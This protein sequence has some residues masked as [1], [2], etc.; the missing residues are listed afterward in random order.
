MF[1]SLNGV[2]VLLVIETNSTRKIMSTALTLRNARAVYSA[3]DGET[4]LVYFRQHAPDIIVTELD[5]SPMSGL[6]MAQRIRGKH[7]TPGVRDVPIILMAGNK[8][9]LSIPHVRDAGF[10]ELLMVPFSVDSLVDRILFTLNNPRQFI[11]TD[12]YAGP[13]RRRYNDPDYTG[14]RRRE[15]D[16]AKQIAHV[17]AG[18]LADPALDTPPGEIPADWPEHERALVMA[19]TLFDHYIKHHELILMK[20]RHAQQATELGFRDPHAQKPDNHRKKYDDLWR[21][22]IGAFSETS[23]TE[24]EIFK[25]ENL[26][27]VIPENIKHEYVNLVN[28]DHK[29]K[30]KEQH[31]DAS[32]YLNVRKDVDHLQSAPNPLS[33]LTA[34][35][36]KEAAV[37]HRTDDSSE[38]SE[39]TTAEKAKSEAKIQYRAEIFNPEYYQKG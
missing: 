32:D 27:N 38:G 31:I 33:G 2:S 24:D 8:E 14:S 37:P 4:A 9:S 19:E 39:K 26:I 17:P 23:V 10:D 30:E 3:G 12:S 16:K 18:G 15:D 35:D 28:N 1:D 5:L 6:K 7:T 29:L 22:I 25:I 34:G 36:Y 20:L 21:E 13:D 11:D